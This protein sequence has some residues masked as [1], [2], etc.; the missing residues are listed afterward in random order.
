MRPERLY[1]NDIVEAVDSIEGF[2]DGIKESEFLKNDLIRSA[3]LQKLTIIGEAAARLPSDFCERY[4]EIPWRD[5]VAFRNIAVHAYFAVEWPIVWFAATEEAPLL[6]NQVAE[7]LA[8]DFPDE[9][10]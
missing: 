1:L 5:I 8:R 7:I 9:T 2:L 10:P 6:R 3:V 4:R